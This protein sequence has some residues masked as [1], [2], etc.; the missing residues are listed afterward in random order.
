MSSDLCFDRCQ[1]FESFIF[2]GTIDSDVVIACFDQIARNLEQKTVVVI[3]NAPVHRSEEFEEKIN[4]WAARGLDIYYL[5]TYC[6][7]LN[8]IEM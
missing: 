4:Q 1:R 8:K 7:S 2:E 6:P 3:D 5:P